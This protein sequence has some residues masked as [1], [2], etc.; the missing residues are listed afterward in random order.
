MTQ[1]G[2]N[3]T[4][5]RAAAAE[6]AG[7]VLDIDHYVPGLLTFL[8]NKLSRGAS[9]LYRRHFQ[10][11]I[12]DWRIMSQLALDPWTTAA[13]VC[14]VI[15][16]DKSV[17]SRSL[18]LLERRGLVVAREEQRRRLMALTEAGRTLH[19]RIILVALERERRLLACLSEAERP[20]LVGMLQRLNR[21]LPEVNKRLDVPA[22]PVRG[23]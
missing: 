1:A 21:Q 17:A 19:D 11:G 10:I 12:N 15:G 13:G 20:V 9:A 3:E 8:A 23:A 2:Q 4:G 22:A 16:I 14:A 6:R 5:A 7:Q 18:G